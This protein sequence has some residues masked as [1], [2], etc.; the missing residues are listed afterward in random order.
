MCLIPSQNLALLCAQFMSC[1][2]MGRHKID[3]PSAGHMDKLTF[4]CG[5]W[6][7]LLGLNS[8]SKGKD[9]EEDLAQEQPVSP[10]TQR[11]QST[12]NSKPNQ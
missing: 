10:H 12:L 7:F 9:I 3:M 1:S 8:S 5:A 11:L 2:F 6:R 4:C